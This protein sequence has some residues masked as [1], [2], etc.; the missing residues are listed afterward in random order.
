MQ[1]CEDAADYLLGKKGS[2][3]VNYLSEG[4]QTIAQLDQAT[5]TQARTES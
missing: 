3:L 5:G 4:L 1:D 2:L